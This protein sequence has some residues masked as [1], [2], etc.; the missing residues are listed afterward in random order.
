MRSLTPTLDTIRSGLP[1]AFFVAAFT[2]TGVRVHAADLEEVTITAPTVKTIGRDAAT[3]API[4]Q[5]TAMARVQYNPIMLTTNSG[6][7]LLEDKV[8]EV[9]RRLC[10][11]DSIAATAIDDDTTCIQQAVAAANV[12]IDAAAARHKGG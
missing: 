1:I 10:R 2:L 5:V 3:G 11:A 12:Q 7:A 8:A 9:A 6:R 4:Q